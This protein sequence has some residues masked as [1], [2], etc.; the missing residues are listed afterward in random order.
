MARTWSRAGVA[1]ALLLA[2]AL[3]TASAL[4]IAAPGGESADD[5]VDTYLDL[6]YETETTVTALYSPLRLAKGV[7][8]KM[9][10]T[11]TLT[12]LKSTA[13]FVA[14]STSTA[15][16]G[17]NS[18]GYVENLT[19]N[20]L[21]GGDSPNAVVI[22][23]GPPSNL[24]SG[25]RSTFSS[26]NN[27][28]Y[29][30]PVDSQL[31]E[32]TTTASWNNGIALVF[33]ATATTG[34]YIFKYAFCTSRTSSAI[35]SALDTVTIT[36]G[37]VGGPFSNVART[38]AVSSNTMT[39]Q[40]RFGIT[41]PE[42]QDGTAYG[43]P[44]TVYKCLASQVATITIATAGT[45]EFRFSAST[46]NNLLAAS[47]PQAYLLVDASTLTPK[48]YLRFV[49]HAEFVLTFSCL[50]GTFLHARAHNSQT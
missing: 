27:K 1:L 45:Y 33:N 17:Y 50:P 23:S 24:V 5:V 48:K 29:P 26:I 16:Y 13:A 3:A 38:S 32:L 9:T 28:A 30:N 14:I 18:T 7:L 6:D 47:F 41:P 22:T 19:T 12:L 8:N 36:Y 20:T 43:L 11:G 35:S 21:V 44:S 31:A 4:K 49:C 15:L 40:L 2:A 39:A 37:P 10:G 46:N 42:G 25:L 34:T